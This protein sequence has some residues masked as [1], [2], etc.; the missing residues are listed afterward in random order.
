MKTDVFEVFQAEIVVG[1][2][3]SEYCRAKPIDLVNSVAKR[4]NPRPGDLSKHAEMD[5]RKGE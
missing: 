2:E 3:H 1:A 5:D 4:A